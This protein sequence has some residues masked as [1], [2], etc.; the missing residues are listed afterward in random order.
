D[1]ER[2]ALRRIYH[3]PA[4]R[5]SSYKVDYRLL[6]KSGISPKSHLLEASRG[7]SFQCRFCVIPAEIGG[8]AGYDLS[9]V[10]AAID[11]A[12]DSSPFLSFRRWY[13]TLIFLDNNFSDDRERM[14][15]IAEL[16]RRD[17]RIRGWAALVTQNVLHDRDLVRRLAQAKCFTLFVGLE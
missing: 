11:S 4:G 17:K 1:F 13:P 12:I 3:S 8:H 2:G 9:A 10:T 5:I 15:R 6:S 14:L 16:L 7:C